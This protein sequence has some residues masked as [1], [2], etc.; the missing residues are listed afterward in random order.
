M[1]FPAA[2]VLATAAVKV[3]IPG[4]Q[5]QCESPYQRKTNQRKKE[6]DTELEKESR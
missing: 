4:A 1:Y 3:Y 2:V 6:G 5:R